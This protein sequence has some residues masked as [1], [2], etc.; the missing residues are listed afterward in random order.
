V[1]AAA[2]R[3]LPAAVFAVLLGA[4]AA[5]C[6][7]GEEEAV[8]PPDEQA[9]APAQTAPVT[10]EVTAGGETTV[11]TGQTETRR[12]EPFVLNLDQPIP[13][14]LRAAYQRRA[15]ISVQFYKTQPDPGGAEA[16][17]YPQGLGVDA[18]VRQAMQELSGEYPT[19]EYFEYEIDNPGEAETSEG[20][21][22]GQYGTLAAQLGVGLTPFVVM[23]APQGDQY[24]IQNLYQGYIPQAVLSQALF[25]LSATDVE[26]AS[27]S[28][29]DVTLD[30]FEL[31]QAGGGLEYITVGNPGD[32]PVNLQGFTIRTLDPET[33]EIDRDSDGVLIEDEVRVP[34]GGQ[35]SV[36]RVPDLVDADGR[37]VAGTFQGGAEL[38]LE[39]GD[40]VALVDPG[41]AVAATI[42]V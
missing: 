17:E 15:L 7:G 35:A 42:S 18:R 11:G 26:G 24:V 30:T 39:P 10:A 41:G 16:V 28:D 34:A 32:S 3:L 8:P 6:G 38:S 4:L 33:G 40:V 2:G 14:D 31:T 29:V 27:T 19:V 1:R 23:L 5:G 13:P 37:R 21:Q 25:D 36:G 20:L 12:N 9:Q 22:Q